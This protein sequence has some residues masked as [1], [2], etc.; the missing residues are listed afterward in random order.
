MWHLYSLL[1]VPSCSLPGALP[2]K[3]CS[4][5][6]LSFAMC[7]HVFLPI[8]DLHTSVSMWQSAHILYSSFSQYAFPLYSKRIFCFINMSWPQIM[9]LVLKYSVMP[10]KYAVS[11]NVGL[12]QKMVWWWWWTDITTRPMQNSSFP[13]CC[14]RWSKS[15]TEGWI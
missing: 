12:F 4:R 11:W 13:S 7:I 6:S 10:L 2:P 5:F 3:F 1:C 8:H 9:L 14:V 15:H